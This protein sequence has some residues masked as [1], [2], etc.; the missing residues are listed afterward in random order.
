M[1][2]RKHYEP[3][4]RH[5]VRNSFARNSIMAE[6]VCVQQNQGYYGLG[7]ATCTECGSVRVPAR[8]KPYLYR[9]HVDDDQGARTSGPIANGRLF[10]CRG[11]AESY[12][13]NSF[14]ETKRY[15]S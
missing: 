12:I 5:I 6:R 11:C 2:H 13:G 14:D 3:I 9:F 15:G 1:A 7:N 10:C 8:G 4:M